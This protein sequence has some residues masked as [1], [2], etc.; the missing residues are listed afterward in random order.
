MTIQFLQELIEKN[1]R[2]ILPEFG[3]FLVKDDGTGV[4][5][6][7]NITFSP[8]LRFNDGVLEE[9][10][11]KGKGVS[12]D[13]ANKQ[14]AAFVEEIK[15]SLLNESSFKVGS[16]GYLYRDSRGSVHFS[17]TEHKSETTDKPSPVVAKPEETKKEEKPA[18]KL[19][20]LAA[21]VPQVSAIP[22]DP[23]KPVEPA[24]PIEPS[25]KVE[26][27][28]PIVKKPI[29]KPVPP[30]KQ[31][32]SVA[33][34]PKSEKPQKSSDSS[35]GKAILIGVLVGVVF[36]ALVITGWY[37]YS[38]GYFNSSED[39]SNDIELT[40]PDADTETETQAVN[41][42]ESKS[43]LEKEFVESKAPVETETPVDATTPVETKAK[44]KPAIKEE[45]KK[46]TT[47]PAPTKPNTSQTQVKI[48]PSTGGSFH[49]IVGSFRN[50]EFAN[51]FSNDLIKSGYTSTVIVQTSGMHAV[52]LGSYQTREEASSAMAQ[53]RS[54]HPNAWILKQ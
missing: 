19:I 3:A 4:F 44:T 49:V 46:Q 33:E 13:E 10:L 47:T 34:V 23:V 51:K 50:E 29:H 22:S 12:K 27:A 6:P 5:K 1:T 20:D 8:F 24:K 42:T 54:Q 40:E 31:K 30:Q 11:T 18:E 41:I 15:T 16:F 35:A 36:I 48:A 17:N 37:F 26:P 9:A 43:E 14:I 7:E 53:Y 32:P 39:L 52:T 25:K 2:V 45:P 21:E 38:N 28:K